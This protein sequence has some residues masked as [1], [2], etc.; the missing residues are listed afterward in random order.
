M[1]CYWSLVKAIPDAIYP[2]GCTPLVCCFISSDL[3][4]KVDIMRTINAHIPHVNI[5]IDTS[6]LPTWA[7]FTGLAAAIR[8]AGLGAESLWY[9]ESFTSWLSRLSFSDM[10]GAI[11]GDV[12]PPA[13]YVIEWIMVRILGHT[14][15]A[16]RLPGALLGILAVLL[17]WQ[18]AL[19]AGLDRRTAFLAGVIASLLPG[20][21]YYSQDARMYPLLACCVLLAAWS[22]IKEWW[23]I[24]ALACL[25]AALTQNLALLY[26]GALAV[27]ILLPRLR[28]PR[29]MVKPV[30]ALA[31]VGVGWSFWLPTLLHQMSLVSQGFWIQPIT[32]GGLL[33]PLASMTMGWRL[34]DILQVHIYGLAF[35]AT[36]V[37][38]IAGRRWI[39]SRSGLI[40]LAVVLGGPMFAAIASI[41]W[42]SIYL[43]RAFLPSALALCILWAGLLTRLSEPNR[44]L[45]RW[46]L[47]PA[48]L[49]GLVAH[50]YPATGAREPIKEWAGIIRANWRTGDVVYHYALNSTM[51]FG[52]Y[53]PDL[54]YA[55]LPQSNDLNQSL[56]EETKRYMGFHQA[57][58]GDLVAQGYKR[59][60][61]VISTNPMSTRLQLDQVR[62]ILTM[63][64]QLYQSYGNDY[65]NESI[66]LVDLSYEQSF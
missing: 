66:Y 55:V 34:P 2:L 45:A 50:Y 22:A 6:V 53:L 29:T 25:E 59:A 49:I 10:L 7:W 44:R 40:M 51:L 41:F 43:P 28:A 58:L 1:A 11:R 56:T 63:P 57:T 62:H 27:A 13:W 46:L 21:V 23:A 60:W 52:N 64:G 48:L 32:I 33:F 16:L 30:L 47:I 35:A 9:D 31:F 24:F 42:R 61:V 26:I 38:L 5:S 4:Y 39:R 36:V 14:D 8:L 17:V 37:G 54:P 18:L 19:A 3:P 65:A 20:A 12:H 15:L